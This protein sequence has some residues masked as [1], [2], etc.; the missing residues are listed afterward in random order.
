[1]DKEARAEFRRTVRIWIDA[2]LDAL[3]DERLIFAATGLEPGI[4][5]STDA[6]PSNGDEDDS[7]TE[8][9][10]WFEIVREVLADIGLDALAM[11]KIF[12][13]NAQKLYDL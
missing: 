7:L 13:G 5:R 10:L 4:M 8:M 11:G 12:E 9:D 1:M 6:A 2:V 3:G